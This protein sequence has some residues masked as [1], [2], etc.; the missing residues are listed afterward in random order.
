MDVFIYYHV[1][2]TE[3]ATRAVVLAQASLAVRWP[4]VKTACFVKHAERDSTLME[5]YLNIVTNEAS[6]V[7]AEIES[8]IAPA[9]KPWLIGER[10]V[11]RFE[12][13]G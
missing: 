3:A 9:V 6:T 8:C 13:V 7:L 11:E 12:R 2:D 1:T 4:C 5:T 10:R